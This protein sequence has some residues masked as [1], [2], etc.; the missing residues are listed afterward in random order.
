MPR[1]CMARIRWVLLLLIFL[2]LIAGALAQPQVTVRKNILR[3]QK[4]TPGYGSSTEVSV[5][6]LFESEGVYSFTDNLVFAECG[7]VT[8]TAPASGYFCRDGR[9]RVSWLNLSVSSGEPLKYTAPGVGLLEVSLVVSAEGQPLQLSCEAGYCRGVA[10]GVREVNYTIILSPSSM[11]PEGVQLPVSISWSIDPAFLYPIAFSENP[12]SLR[13]SG[14]EI[15]FQWSVFLSGTYKLSVVFEVRGENPWGEVLV[16]APTIT[17][18]LDPRLQLSL[19]ERYRSLM[20]SFMERSLGNLTEMRNNITKLRDLLLNL[21]A[22]LE[23]QSAMLASAAGA[24]D[25]ASDAISVA[26]YQLS[27]AAQTIES[28][29]SALKRGLENASNA[30]K[31]ARELAQRALENAEELEREFSKLNITWVGNYTFSELVNQAKSTLTTMQSQLGSYENLLA[32]YSIAKGSLY[33]GVNEL[34]VAASQL[35]KLGN[36]LREGSRGMAQLAKGFREAAE[37]IDSTILKLASSLEAQPYPEGLLEFNRTITSQVVEP[38]GEV[39]VK[40]ELMSDVVYV[41]LPLLKLKRSEPQALTLPS[42]AA[43][44]R[45]GLALEL[46][47]LLLVAAAT[48]AV[49]SKSNKRARGSEQMLA[50]IR[51]LRERLSRLEVG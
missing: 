48:Y 10:P 11:I 24:A 27:S 2:N 6:L 36:M 44:R 31:L 28:A 34:R 42:Y 30:L 23:E 18:S 8:S 20:A 35:R 3:V 13:E 4:V 9:L 37:L 45:S 25:Q 5:T 19:I 39:S 46:A 12:Q 16:P 7:S 38:I 50:E 17:A 15:S 32:Q 41:S 51:Q 21:S 29:E 22:Q 49:L 26:V 43:P 47:A 1:A 33:T 40:S 14:T